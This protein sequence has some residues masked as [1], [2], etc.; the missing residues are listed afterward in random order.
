MKNKLASKLQALFVH[1]I[2]ITYYPLGFYGI[3]SYEP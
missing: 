3:T 1:T 2:M